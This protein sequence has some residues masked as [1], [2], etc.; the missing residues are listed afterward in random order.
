MDISMIGD[1]PDMVQLA[2]MSCD[3]PPKV[4]AKEVQCSVSAIY[5]SAKGTRQIPAKSMREFAKTNLIAAAS[6]AMQVTGLKSFFGYRKGD[7]HIQ[8]RLVELKMYDRKADEAMQ[9]LPEMLFN[10]N[11]CE[12]LT[13][14][15]LNKLLNAVQRMVERDNVSFNLMMELDV[16]YQLNL[17]ETLQEGGE[18]SDR[19]RQTA[20]RVSSVRFSNITSTKHDKQCIMCDGIK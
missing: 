17:A 3:M 9:M 1:L 6:M 13:D 2:V 15:D 10:K 19:C 8:S 20:S 14:E 4:L 5:E 12:D 16:K 11:T 18:K 7:R